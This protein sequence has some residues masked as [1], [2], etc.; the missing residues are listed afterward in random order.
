MRILISIS[1]ILCISLIVLFF[2]TNH[3]SKITKTNYKDYGILMETKKT[4]IS[5]TIKRDTTYTT[6][7]ITNKIQQIE[8]DSI[9]KSNKILRFDKTSTIDRKVT[10]DKKVTINKDNVINNYYM[11]PE[12]KTSWQTYLAYFL[13]LIQ[14]VITILLGIKTLKNKKQNEK[15]PVQV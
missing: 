9:S 1:V 3:K 2:T 8:T 15:I 4:S 7:K 13:G 11:V 5:D 10:K 12:E 6:N 14:T